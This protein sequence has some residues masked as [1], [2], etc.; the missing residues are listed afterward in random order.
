MITRTPI[1]YELVARNLPRN[2][3]PISDDAI[4][5]GRWYGRAR[6]KAWLRRG[7]TE[8]ISHYGVEQPVYEP[9]YSKVNHGKAFEI[10]R[11]LAAG[12]IRGIKTW[13]QKEK[14]PR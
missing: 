6:G 14:R 7:Q 8:Y 12:R 10:I 4:R 2:R 1:Y 11:G 9:A 3:R 13:R 5:Q